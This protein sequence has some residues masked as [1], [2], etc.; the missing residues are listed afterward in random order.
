VFVEKREKQN[1]NQNIPKTSK[2]GD[3]EHL[4]TNQN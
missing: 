1:K 3:L 2:I 4:K